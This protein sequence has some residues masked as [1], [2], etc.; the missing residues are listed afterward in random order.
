MYMCVGMYLSVYYI[1]I[2]VCMYVCMYVCMHACMYVR[3]NVWLNELSIHLLLWD[4]NSW[5]WIQI[6]SNQWLK[7]WYLSLPSQVLGIIMIWAKTG[8]FSV[9][10][11][12]LS[13][14]SGHGAGN[15]ISQFGSTTK[16]PWVCT[17]TSW[18]L[19]WLPYMLP[20]YKIP[21]NMNVYM[22]ICQWIAHILGIAGA[23]LKNRFDL[24]KKDGRGSVGWF[25]YPQWHLGAVWVHPLGSLAAHSGKLLNYYFIN[26]TV[27]KMFQITFF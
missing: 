21:T 12:W 15:L 27:F 22:H 14:I 7:D 16:S 3:M 18:Y 26:R 20:G 5:A 23:R 1:C 19:P 25:Q 9:R 2:C 13:E 17:V 24:K 10:I 11:T 6:A 8:W 4:S